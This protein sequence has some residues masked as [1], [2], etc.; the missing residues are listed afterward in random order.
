MRII[1]NKYF[2]DSTDITPEIVFDFDTGVMQIKG[3]SIP[4]NPTEFF[5]PVLKVLKSKIISSKTDKMVFEIRLAYI[6]TASSKYLLEM[7]KLMQKQK[8]KSVEVHWYRV[9][10]DES[11]EELGEIFQ[12]FLNFDFKFIEVSEK[13]LFS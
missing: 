13:K 9:N 11:M 2:I 8:D 5:D 6:G 1:N 12:E 3:V 4:E 7:L 10:E